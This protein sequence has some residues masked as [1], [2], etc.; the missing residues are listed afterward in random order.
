MR[1]FARQLRVRPHRRSVV[2][3]IS[4]AISVLL[5][6]GVSCHTLRCDLREFARDRSRPIVRLT[7]VL[8]VAQTPTCVDADT[9]TA[10]QFEVRRMPL[11]S[12]VVRV[13]WRGGQQIVHNLTGDFAAA[14]Y[15][16]VSFDARHFLFV[17]R[18]SPNDADSVFEMETDGTGVREV[19]QPM[20]GCDQPVYLS[21]VFTV[22]AEDPIEQIGFRAKGAGGGASAFFRCRCDGTEVQ[23]ITF[24]PRGVTDPLLLS[25]GRLLFSMP[26][27]SSTAP[28]SL[29]TAC[30]TVGLISVHADGTDI[31]PLNDATPG[32]VRRAFSEANDE[33]VVFSETVTGQS[34]AHEELLAVPRSR[35]WK[36]RRLTDTVG[37][38]VYASVST[39][40]TGQLLVASRSVAAGGTFGIHLV[41][42]GTGRTIGEVFDADS[43]HDVRAIAI[44]P[45]RKPAGRSTVVS[46]AS[47]VGQLYCLNAYQTDGDPPAMR[48]SSLIARVRVYGLSEKADAFIPRIETR[49][50]GD[51]VTHA[52]EYR[53]VDDIGQPRE[54][55][56]GEAAVDG[57]GSF[58]LELPAATPIRLETLDESGNVL[59]S[60]HTWFWV[61]PMERRGCIG[62]HEDRR[63][64][65]PN[66]Q[67]LALRKPPQRLSEKHTPMR[68]IEECDDRSEP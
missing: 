65:P 32:V 14:G 28:R 1:Q 26:L 55:V 5:G 51:Q 53:G 18:R 15:P 43:W 48:E 8:L 58:F 41:D 68:T 4:V 56:L 35:P 16:S 27:G 2:T 20:G 33:L 9:I 63:L 34:G 42:R 50:L 37:K 10:P 60:M 13:E 30:A 36:M 23:Q 45:R 3:H 12:R 7:Q 57:D 66:H 25:D 17:G 61:M 19:I 52:R 24:A 39:L 62:C 46:N 40:A 54:T 6:G 47:R 31:F 22:D 21:S 67:V 29:D 44:E 49:S 59:R 64:T 11:G 38:E